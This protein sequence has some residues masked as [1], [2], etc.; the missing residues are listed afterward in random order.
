MQNDLIIYEQQGNGGSIG[1]VVLN[2]PSRLN[3]VNLDNVKLIYKKL[4]QWD[5]DSNIKAVVIRSNHESFFCSGGDLKSIYNND[6][7]Y[8]K[9]KFWH[10]Y[11]LIAKI[12][13]LT[14]PYISLINGITM[15]G[16]VG[17]SINGKFCISATNL[18]FAM[19]ETII[20]FFPD[21]GA[22]YFLPK[23]PGNI[24]LYLGLTGCS[25]TADDALFCGFIDYIIEYENFT[26]IIDD[27]NKTNLD[28][29]SEEKLQDIFKQYALPKHKGN[30]EQHFQ[31][32]NNTFDIPRY[33][34]PNSL[35]VTEKLL[36]SNVISI[37]AALQQEFQLACN[38]FKAHD[39]KEGI[40]AKL[41][42]KDNK[43]TWQ[44]SHNYNIEHFFQNNEGELRFNDK[45]VL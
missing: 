26:Q 33:N 31:D 35:R 23:A 15:G 37:N 41:I 20:G 29:N 43:P 10:E 42:N 39:F 17:L 30:I 1:V 18:T 5:S 27:I 9:A 21:V 8:A 44:D 28:L 19:P 32:I 38:F 12:H 22:S 2:M 13:S 36:T 14:K 40:R 16:G 6:F 3:A 11:R 25:I 45:D 24:G 4:C 7:S 34:S